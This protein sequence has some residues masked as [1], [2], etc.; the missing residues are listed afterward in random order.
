WP[1]ASSASARAVPAGPAPT[2]SAA[3]RSPIARRRREQR[4]DPLPQVLR[5]ALLRAGA[6]QPL[7][8][9]ALEA[10]HVL[11]VVAPLEVLLHPR[12]LLH[13]HLAAHEG[14]ELVARPPAIV[15]CI[16]AIAH[17]RSSLGGITPR[18]SA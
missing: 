9:R 14:V 1:R 6:A 12:G 16:P 7:A 5:A 11:A 2:T 17:R 10:G 18:S 3:T 8:E 13:R 4:L 15:S